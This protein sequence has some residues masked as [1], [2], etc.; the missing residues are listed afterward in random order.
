[1]NPSPRIT[2]PLCIYPNVTFSCHG[3]CMFYRRTVLSAVS[4]CQFH[5]LACEQPKS[6][7]Q[8]QE[9]TCHFTQFHHFYRY[10]GPIRS[11][12]HNNTSI[13]RLEA[14]RKLIVHDMDSRQASAGKAIRTGASQRNQAKDTSTSILAG[15]AKR[16]G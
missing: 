5:L 9:A 16:H 6:G 8:Q 7:Q 2:N 1:M 4:L 11:S 14:C 12:S 15:P 10:I 13:K 3:K